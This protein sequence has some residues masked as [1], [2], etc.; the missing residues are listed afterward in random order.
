MI[1]EMSI[2]HEEKE[3]EYVEELMKDATPKEEKIIEKNESKLK[4]FGNGLKKTDITYE[5]HR[6]LAHNYALDEARKLYGDNLFSEWQNWVVTPISGT[7]GLGA[8][9]GL[10]EVKETNMNKIATAGGIL[11]IAVGVICL[12]LG[13]KTTTKQYLKSDIF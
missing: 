8:T 9:A 3:M 1:N 7:A 4:S 11:A 10:D 5:S 6:E 13:I 2:F 12:L